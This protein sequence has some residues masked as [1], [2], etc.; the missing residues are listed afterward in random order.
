MKQKS[1]RA[2]SMAAKIRSIVKKLLK[3][4]GG[5]RILTELQTEI[6][7]MWNMQLRS[8]CLRGSLEVR[9][10]GIEI[11]FDT[12]PITI[13]LKNN[14]K[15]K[16]VKKVAKKRGR[17]AKSKGQQRLG[18]EEFTLLAIKK[19]SEPPHKAIHSVYSGFNSAFRRYFPI[20][21][22]VKEVQKLDKTG[23]VSIR[24]SKGGVIIF[25]GKENTP[26]GSAE[27]VLAKMGLK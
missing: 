1:K 18:P 7:Q 6:E 5:E 25:A 3:E 2:R 26:S 8:D 9:D 16:E 24:P 19:L 20:L 17:K 27:K 22:P 23:K 13:S 10:S 15:R 21:D 11:N 4:A 14:L 12:D